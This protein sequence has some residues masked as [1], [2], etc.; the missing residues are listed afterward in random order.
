MTRNGS[1]E[2]L[3]TMIFQ[4]NQFILAS[5]GSG[6]VAGGVRAPAANLSISHALT[7]RAVDPK[8]ANQMSVFPLLAHPAEY[9]PCLEDLKADPS[10]REYWIGRFERHL[11][12]LAALPH[13]SGRLETAPRFVEFRASYW[14]GLSRL[15][16]DPDSEERITVLTICEFRTRQLRRFGFADAFAELKRAQNDA[17]MAQLA[18]HLRRLDALPDA[19][20]SL[21]RCLLAANIND[22]GSAEALARLNEDGDSLARAIERLPQRPWRFDQFDAV[23]ARLSQLAAAGERLM[24]FVDNGG[25][26]FV[27]AVI[28]TAREIARR[29]GSVCLAANSGPALNDVTDLEARSLLDRAAALDPILGEGWNNGRIQVVD[30]GCTEPLLDLSHVSV[31]CAAA[32]LGCSGLMLMGMGRSIETNYHAAFRVDCVRLGLVKDEHVAGLL[33]VPLFEPICRLDPA[34]S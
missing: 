26:E 8:A 27:L 33:G 20:E 11:K 2:W 7:G 1:P 23:V 31:N 24:L 18:G 5:A 21:V 29:G 19:M 32:A 28:P 17:A 16:A 30:S 34:A 25:P 22:F 13:P 9:L 6:D 4:R 12:T 3:K 15:R 10:A 14:K